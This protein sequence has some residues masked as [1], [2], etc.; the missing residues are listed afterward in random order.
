MKVLSSLW[1]PSRRQS[2]D[3]LHVCDG[4]LPFL[5][6]KFWSLVLLNFK[7]NAAIWALVL[8]AFWTARAAGAG[9]VS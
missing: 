5:A 4:I 1:T 7:A 3:Q 2:F 8:A 6:K 9:G